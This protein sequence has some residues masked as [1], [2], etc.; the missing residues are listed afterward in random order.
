MSTTH[1]KGSGRTGDTDDTEEEQ[2]QEVLFESP[3][4]EKVEYIL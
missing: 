3:D 1:F 2:E 4:T